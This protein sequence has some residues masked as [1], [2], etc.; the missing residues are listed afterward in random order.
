[1]DKEWGGRGS[2]VALLNKES[3][4]FPG[5]GPWPSQAWRGVH[6]QLRACLTSQHCGS[7]LEFQVAP[8]DWWRL[9][10]T[11][12]FLVLAGPQREESGGRMS[13]DLVLF[14]RAGNKPVLTCLP[15]TFLSACL[16]GGAGGHE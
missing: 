2:E 6:S 3:A 16:S 8:L 13:I 5:T 12:R 15:D 10:L 7:G 4:A 9:P 11:E 14:V 1:M